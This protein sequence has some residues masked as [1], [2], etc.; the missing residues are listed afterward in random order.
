MGGWSL[1]DNPELQG[2]GRC[3]GSVSG[4]LL[5]SANSVRYILERGLERGNGAPLTGRGRIGPRLEWSV[6]ESER[7]AA[8]PSNIP[9]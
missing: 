9:W 5:D 2:V 6:V 8:T 7:S 4:H 1:D 3:S